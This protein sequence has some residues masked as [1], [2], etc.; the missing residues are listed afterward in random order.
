M[1]S[2][3]DSEDE[4]GDDEEDIG[5][6]QSFASVDDLDGKHVT[7][8]TLLCLTQPRRG[9][10]RSHT[11]ASETRRKRPGVL[12]VPPRKRPRTAGVR[13]GRHGGG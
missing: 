1:P 12:Q 4:D 10:G 3:A 11:R 9:W 7:L 2:A 6:D 5:D 13:S 8:V